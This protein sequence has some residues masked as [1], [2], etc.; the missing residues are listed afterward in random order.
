MNPFILRKG[1]S[2]ELDPFP[3]ILE[4]GARK[5]QQIRLD[6]LPVEKSEHF[7]LYYIW[8]GRYEWQIDGRE[9]LLFPSDLAL[10]TPGGHFGN[11]RQILDIGVFSHLSLEIGAASPF[12]P[13]TSL[14]PTE[15]R[16][17]ANLI[18][19]NETPVISGIR[20]LGQLFQSLA[21]E[22]H[23]QEI[24]YQTRVRNLIDS[25]LIL[26]A[27]Q[28]IRQ[29]HSQRD[30]PRTFMKLEQQLRANLAHQWTVEEM[31]ALVGLGTTTFTE[32][33][34]G[35]TGFPPLAYLINIRISEAIRLLKRTE[36]PL[37]GIALETGFYSSQHFSTTFRKLTGYTP[38][39]FRKN[40]TDTI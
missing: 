26:I 21:N 19:N 24:G 13:W 27:R 33:V 2:K 8:D 4:F 23:E 28:L 9:Y 34:K 20:P 36:L 6:S 22:F 1:L 10:V 17:V 5:V 32:K 16:A 11:S 15:S 40:N 7:S 29:T 3:H 18:L 14:T 30:F 37:T 38:S 12:A 31:A 39:Q 25:L 35:Y